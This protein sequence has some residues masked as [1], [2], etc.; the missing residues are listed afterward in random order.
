[1]IKV[2]SLT[3]TYTDG[4]SKVVALDN[5]SLELEQGDD[6]AI[7][8]PSGSGKTTLLQLMGGINRPTSGTVTIHNRDVWAGN[9]NTIS[10][11]RNETMGFVFQM[12]YLQ[13]YLT[14]I[15]N[16][17]IPMLI[18]GK[19]QAEARKHALELLAKVDLQDRSE[20]LPKEMSGG[21]MQRVGVARALS[22]N[23][24]IIFA[25]EPTGK[26]D[27][28]NS[29]N[30]IKILTDIAKQENMSVIMITHD[31]SIAK[32]FNNILWLE[33]GKMKNFAKNTRSTK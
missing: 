22:N 2:E 12:I 11:F 23:P 14:A 30:I 17:M 5:I 27:K 9:D 20:H 10:K 13:E 16:V 19:S 31:E 15:E 7:V 29:K 1:M 6:L 4:R 24:K 33:H 28:K 26:L 18:A 32:D 21:E 3:K 25:D 8:G